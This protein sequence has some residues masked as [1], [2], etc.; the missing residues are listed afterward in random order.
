MIMKW[1][2]GSEATL[3]VCHGCPVQVSRTKKELRLVGGATNTRSFTRD[4]HQSITCSWL[5]EDVVN[6]YKQDFQ[7]H[8]VICTIQASPSKYVSCAQNIYY[9]SKFSSGSSTTRERKLARSYE[10]CPH[11]MPNTFADVFMPKFM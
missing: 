2:E 1:I 6:I 9:H 11:A 10:V 5:Q 8:F 7:C 3:H 4:S